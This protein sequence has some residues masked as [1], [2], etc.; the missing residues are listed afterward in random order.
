[1]ITKTFIKNENG[2]IE[3]TER[4]LKNL[5]DEVFTN[6][7][8]EGKGKSTY[9]YTSPFWMDWNK[10]IYTY[11]TPATSPFSVSYTTTAAST[12][13]ASSTTDSKKS[14]GE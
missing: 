5:L 12:T 6:G 14:K 9:T 13:T 1:M 10:P 11:T 7:F 4:E 8:N 2:K 3:F